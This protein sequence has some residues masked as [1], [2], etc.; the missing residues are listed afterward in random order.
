MEIEARG[1]MNGKEERK[2][3]CESCSADSITD[4]KVLR[5]G[6]IS[7]KQILGHFLVGDLIDP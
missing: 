1:E 6:A 2:A 7:E 5:K 4:Q 3:S